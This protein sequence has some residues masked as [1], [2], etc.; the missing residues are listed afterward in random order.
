MPATIEADLSWPDRLHDVELRRVGLRVTSHSHAVIIPEAA[1]RD[2]EP[3]GTYP[4]RLKTLTWS[5]VV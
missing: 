4:L 2:A 1:L 3:N 5:L